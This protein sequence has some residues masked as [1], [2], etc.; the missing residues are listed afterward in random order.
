MQ[1][2]EVPCADSTYVDD[3]ALMISADSFAQLQDYTIQVAQCADAVFTSIGMKMNFA[4][5][6]TEVLPFFHGKGCRAAKRE[7][8]MQANK[9]FAIQTAGG[10]T[11][12]HIVPSYVH[13]G[14]VLHT[15]LSWD[16]EVKS[17]AGRAHRA[18]TGIKALLASPHLSVQAK[19][20][21]IKCFVS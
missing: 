3:T 9:S 11:Q 6:K 13:L 21:L 16:L 2:K 1:D 10:E 18:V 7:W 4:R 12:L 8:L 20:H 17:R 15:S 19:H 5:Q 14:T